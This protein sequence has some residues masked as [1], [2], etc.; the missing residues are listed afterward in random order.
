MATVSKQ[1][2]PDATGDGRWLPAMSGGGDQH[3]AA[4]PVQ[5]KEHILGKG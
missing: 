5:E 3:Q 1:W 2:R 4:R